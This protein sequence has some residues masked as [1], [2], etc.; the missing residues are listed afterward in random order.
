MFKTPADYKFAETPDFKLV[1]EYKVSPNDIVVFEI[2]S[3]KGFNLINITSFNSNL[4]GNLSSTNT[5]EYQVDADGFVKLPIVGRKQL[6]GLT[7]REL[8]NTLEESY[9]E[10]YNNPFVVAQI[11]NRKVI[12]FSGNVSDAKI[13]PL[14][15]N[16]T[17]LL[18]LIAKEGGMSVNG[19]ARKVKLIRDIN[20]VH[21]VYLIDLSTIAGIDDAHIVLQANDIIYIEPRRKVSSKA[22]TEIAPVLSLLSSSLILIFTVDRL[23]K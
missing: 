14:T 18:Q 10:F 3:N 8:E 11:I 17:T 16:N 9:S 15:D 5:P 12:Y 21:E 19:K 20:G 7:L 1:P 22:L 2:Y 13:I 4:T 23:T 6:S